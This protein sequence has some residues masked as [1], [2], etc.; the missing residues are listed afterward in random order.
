MGTAALKAARLSQEASITLTWTPAQ[1]FSQTR[2]GEKRMWGPISRMSA[3]ADSALS[4]KLTVR[5]KSRALATAIICSPT[6]GR[7]RKETNSSVSNFG[8]TRPRFSAMDR[9]LAWLSMA[10]F[11]KPVVPEVVQIQAG[12]SG[13]VCSTLRSKSPGWPSSNW[14]P[15]SMTSGKWISRSEPY[16]LMPLGS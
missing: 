9:R 7:G 1:R 14:R 15:R 13:L 10:S 16:R 12:S 4:G 2:G 5:P 8:S 6:Q 11:G 3:W